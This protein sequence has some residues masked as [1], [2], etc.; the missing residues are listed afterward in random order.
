MFLE[1]SEV[2]S[3]PGETRQ[4]TIIVCASVTWAIGTAFV[5]ARVYTRCFIVKVFGLEDWFI[6]LAFVGSAALSA[7][8][9]AQAAFGLGRHAGDIDPAN[10]VNLARCGWTSIL[11]YPV[12]LLMTKLSTLILYIKIFSHSIYK[13]WTYALIAVV[14]ISSTFHIIVVATAC[15]PLSAVWDRTVTGKCH[16]RTYWFAG[17]SMHVV[18]DFLIVLLPLPV[19]AA[20]KATLR[21]R[22]VL[23]CIFTIGFFV[24]VV[25]ALR[26][27]AVV[28]DSKREYSYDIEV[29]V[30]TCIEV[31][32]AIICPCAMTLK[33]LVSKLF[34]G[35]LSHYV[36]EPN[37]GGRFP[38]MQSGTRMNSG[39]LPTKPRGTWFQV[40][41][42]RSEEDLILEERGFDN[43]A[44]REMSAQSS[45]RTMPAG[46]ESMSR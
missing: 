19:V 8:V 9:I 32:V 18:T 11:F 5:W 26:F 39:S 7:S 42:S 25:S 41:D 46:E 23:G 43:V 33:P 16:S 30:W 45:M 14:V 34:P 3:N 28:T 21:Q 6:L 10:V 40:T 15:V 36:T 31:N 13:R 20:L 22:I 24:S 37:S 44:L 1:R 35:L 2:I 4:S 17:F 27:N 38:S 12:A 29:I